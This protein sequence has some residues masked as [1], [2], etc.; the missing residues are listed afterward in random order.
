MP[1]ARLLP[2]TEHRPN[3]YHR[4]SLQIRTLSAPSLSY[5]AQNHLFLRHCQKKTKFISPASEH[6]SNASRSS[7]LF[8]DSNIRVL[9]EVLCRQEGAL[10]YNLK[11]RT[12]R[13]Y[14][15]GLEA[16]KHCELDGCLNKL[17]DVTWP[18][19]AEEAR[20]TR[21]QALARKSLKTHRARQPR[22]LMPSPGRNGLRSSSNRT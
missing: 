19:L 11:T 20:G 22:E 9:L 6:Q 16:T 8:P 12:F 14:V 15:S 17:L 5:N 21:Q 7:E 10:Q 13:S 3:C 4:Q 18:V 1:G 2:Q